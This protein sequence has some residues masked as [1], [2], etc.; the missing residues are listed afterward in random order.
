MQRFAHQLFLS[1]YVHAQAF[2]PKGR[3]SVATGG[4]SPAAK[5]AERNPWIHSRLNNPAP[6]GRRELH[7]A[8]RML[9][10]IVERAGPIAHLST[11]RP[12]PSPLRGERG[13]VDRFST[14]SAS[15]R[16]AAAP[17]HPWLSAFGG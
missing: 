1:A 7:G 15:G 5:R 3:R 2:A 6:E 17:L 9:R 16:Y 11:K 8:N 4:A 12:S 14:G 13:M 10:S